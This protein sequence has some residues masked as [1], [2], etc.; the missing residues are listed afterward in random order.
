MTLA[1]AA[2]LVTVT[3][4]A[5]GAT[6]PIGRAAAFVDVVAHEDDDILFMNPDLV[7]G[8]RAGVPATT[9]FLTAGENAFNGA[10]GNDPDDP[11][12]PRL[13]ND[14][15][16]HFGELSRERY[17]Q[18]RQQA[19][20]A[21][22]AQM[23]GVADAWDGTLVDVSGGNFA[24]QYTLR[25][26]PSIKLVF[27]DLPE[28]G[29]SEIGGSLYHLYFDDEP[30]FATDT[31]VPTDG[32]VQRSYRYDRADTINALTSLYQRFAPTAVRV[33]DTDPDAREQIG[34]WIFHDHTD[35][36]MAARLA[37]E[38]LGDYTRQTGY[39][40]ISL[41]EFRDYN[42]GG[43][44]VNLAP[45]QRSDKNATFQAYKPLDP[46]VWE[47]DSQNYTDW[48]ARMYYRW[49]TGTSWVGHDQD[50]RLEAFAVRGGNL[51]DWSQTSTG[52]WTGPVDLGNP[53]GPLEPGVAVANERD[54]RLDVFARRADTAE[55]VELGQ[56]APNGAWAA[57]WSSLGNPNTGDPDAEQQVGTPVTAKNGDGRIE[58]F[59]RNGGGGVST[60]FQQGSGGA[61]GAWVDL[62]GSGIQ[63]DPAAVTTD[64]GRI[65]LFAST[66]TEVLH[67]Y[68]PSPNSSF[69]VDSS[70]PAGTPA[71]APTAA[72]DQDGRLSVFYRQAGSA[73]VEVSVQASPDGGWKPSPVVLGGQAGVGQPALVTA[74]PSVDARVMVFTRNGGGG[75]SSARQTSANGGFGGWSDLGGLFV[76]LPTAAVDNAG[77]V[78]LL[79]MGV[80][81]QLAVNR[82]TAAGGDAPFGGWQLVG[83]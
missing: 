3:Q 61:F 22:Y 52:S 80:G 6:A 79:A 11:Y 53:G 46:A 45:G 18:C 71:S 25:A 78:V 59:V 62:G 37:S 67:W 83:S 17:A 20:R 29:D 65:E 31:L 57:R 47:V 64:S 73:S 30:G 66:K 76:G 2:S 28:D 54:D 69:T 43:A 75:V 9:I 50:G 38:A 27:L 68:Q 55:I 39:D 12:C 63:E 5:I 40:R 1:L 8:I 15:G 14:G 41:E 82:Q 33:Q 70:F 19:A 7:G 81:G 16:N 35:H 58:V 74:P 42:I 51:L 23:A 32:V 48:T 36:V 49:P 4:P 10:P 60:S 44:P 77:V 21:A 56:T 24:E 34:A 26:K 13:P 72:I